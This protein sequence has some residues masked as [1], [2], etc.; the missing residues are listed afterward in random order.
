MRM[1]H[2]AAAKHR[3]TRTAANQQIFSS[4]AFQNNT[5]GFL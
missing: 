3:A 1:L 4:A 5:D 2:Q